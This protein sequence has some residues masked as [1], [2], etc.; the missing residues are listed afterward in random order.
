[1]RTVV[2]RVAAVAC[3]GVASQSA[4]EVVAAQDDTVVSEIVPSASVEGRFSCWLSV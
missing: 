3:I 4:E 2:D 1:M